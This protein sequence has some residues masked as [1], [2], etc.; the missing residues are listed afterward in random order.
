MKKKKN[1]EKKKKMKKEENEVLATG[2]HPVLS[3]VMLF[4]SSPLTFIMPIKISP[5][6]SF[7]FVLTIR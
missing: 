4:F 1:E 6:H 7:A 3:T 2:M 5:S